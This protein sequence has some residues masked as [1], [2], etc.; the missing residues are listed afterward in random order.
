M[1]SMIT[2][3]FISHLRGNGSPMKGTSR[4]SN[5]ESSEGGEDGG[6]DSGWFL[7]SML[8]R[9][10]TQHFASFSLRMY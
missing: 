2:R 7:S 9:E 10:Q 1:S 4:S 3:E 5:G 6:N 8:R